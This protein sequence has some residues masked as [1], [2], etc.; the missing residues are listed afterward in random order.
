MAFAVTILTFC[1]ILL[2]TKRFCRFGIFYQ[3]IIYFVISDIKVKVMP[4]DLETLE[5]E[6]QGSEEQEENN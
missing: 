3:K 5:K 6:I 2:T 4:I 1:I